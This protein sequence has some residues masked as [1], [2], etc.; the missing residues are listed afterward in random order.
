M[1]C[2]ITKEAEAV[3]E[4]SQL[5]FLTQ[6]VYTVS[7]HIFLKSNKYCKKVNAHILRRRKT[8][9]DE[10]DRNGE[11]NEAAGCGYD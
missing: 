5:F 4:R 9:L 3:V 8:G 2:E 10:E 6:K 7:D 11:G 1:L